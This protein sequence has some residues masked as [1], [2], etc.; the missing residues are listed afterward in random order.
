MKNRSFKFG[1]TAIAAVLTLGLAG[2]AS[3]ECM[4]VGSCFDNFTNISAAGTAG[5]GGFGAVTFKGLEGY[6]QVEKT[7]NSS[8]DLVL[9]VASDG[10]PGGCGT[11][12]INFKAF[13]G[14]T[15]TA[16]G[17]AWTNTPGGTASVI[18]ETGAFSAATFQYGIKNY[19][20][21]QTQ[22]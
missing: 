19:N 2:T 11:V 10:C 7:G 1:L 4:E 13:S 20:A 16:Q 21:P 12:G 14:E 8:T 15:V 3:A 22:P 5:S 9:K 18:N 6:G 17:A